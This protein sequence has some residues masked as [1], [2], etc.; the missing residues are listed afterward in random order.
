MRR[1]I[2]LRS[3]SLSPTTGPFLIRTLRCLRSVLRSSAAT[4]SSLDQR[5]AAR[6]SRACVSPSAHRP[7]TGGR[8]RRTACSA[9][10]LDDQ[11]VEGRQDMH[12]SPRRVPEGRLRASPAAA[13][14][15]GLA[16]A[17]IATGTNSPRRMRASISLRTSALAP[18]HRDGRSNPGSPCPGSA[19]PGQAGSR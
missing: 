15:S 19:R 3:D 13:Q 11:R 9:L 5:P 10:A 17:S 2:S 6:N 7:R 14:C 16:G 8:S 4:I 12:Q 18:G 1:F